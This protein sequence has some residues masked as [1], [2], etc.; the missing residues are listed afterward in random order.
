MTGPAQAGRQEAAGYKWLALAVVV[1]GT[2]MAILDSSIVN[3]AIPKMMAVFGSNTDQIQWVL[4]GY[5]MTMGIVIPLSGYLSDIF[6]TKKVYVWALAVFTLGSA[7]CGIAWS[8]NSMVTARVL[9]A[10][11]AGVMM[12]VSMAIIYQVIPLHQRGF[13]LGLWGIAAMA[14]PTIGP[15]LSGYIVE[16]LNWR[17]IFTINLP[18]GVIGVILASILLREMPK[19]PARG[20]DY[21]G[22]LTSSVGLGTLLLALSKGHAE[23]WTSFYIVSLLMVSAASL[24][25]FVFIEL[26]V[27]NPMLDLRLLQ[28]RNYSVSII[29]ASLL[30]IGL[31]GG[32]FL[33]PIFLENIRGLTA[34]QTGLLMFPGA[35]ATGITM[36]ISGRLFDKYGAKPLVTTGLL[37]LVW[38]TYR[39]HFL[40]LDTS[41]ETLR[42]LFFIRGIGMGFAMMPA[43]TAGMNSVP[44]NKV[45]RASALSN[46][47]RQI[48]GSLGIAAL[49]TI[50]QQRQSFHL[51]RIAE[52]ISDFN[53]N[54]LDALNL[55]QGLLVRSGQSAAEAGQTIPALLSGLVQRSAAVLAIEE[56][57]LVTVFICA[58]AIP[59]VFLLK[60]Q[61]RTAGQA[62]GQAVGSAGQAGAQT[63]GGLPELPAET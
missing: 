11:G 35:L 52:K 9:Q 2:F 42:N 13:A 41:P 10:V 15:T 5:M 18:V 21:P 27:K 57:F 39:L 59:L 23:G 24:L 61:R 58:A 56:T 16:N 29:I 31:F 48:A 3:I 36:P 28:I 50:M 44:Q 43:T 6:G 55:F 53:P 19:N 40:D 51:V 14:A 49:T 37:I 32:I 62:A 8:N 22:F 26:T 4:T 38:S 20:F 47:V 63:A 45:A 17:L 46:V 60:E 34:M 1:I 33:L 7:F 54:T 25:S 30:G 12:P